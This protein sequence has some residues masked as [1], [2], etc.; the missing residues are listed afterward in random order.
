MAHAAGDRTYKWAS[1]L[2]PQPGY[3]WPQGADRGDGPEALRSAFEVLGYEVCAGPDLEPGY[4]KVALYVDGDGLWS[5]AARQEANGDWS[6][7]LGTEEDVR[8]RTPHAFSGSIYGQVAYYLRRPLTA[9][10]PPLPP[11]L[12]RRPG[13]RRRKRGR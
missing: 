4:E 13:P 2:F 7:K 9:P 5:H 12:P 6:S 8:H 11:P 10:A 3:H 1:T